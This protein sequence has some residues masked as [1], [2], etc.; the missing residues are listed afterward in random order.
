MPDSDFNGSNTETLDVLRQLRE[1]IMSGELAPGARLHQVPLSEALGISRTPLREAMA[2]LARDGLLEYAPNRGYS[3]RAFKWADIEQAYAVRARLEGMASA[4]C[5]RQGIPA[6]IAARLQACLETGDQILA[7]GVLRPDD[8]PPYRAMNVAFHEAILEAA[9]N[10][11]I[12]DF[13]R[14]TQNVPLASDRLFI[15]EDHATILRSHDD[16]HRI[17]HCIVG[18]DAE[19][20]E[21]LMREHIIFAGQ[22]LKLIEGREPG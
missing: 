4:I 3:V 1:R 9:G 17:V 6:G 8:L 18:G 5:A 13:V 10:I 16:H 12:S 2:R 19:R 15:W 14:Q 11:W 7:A 20:A 21:G 22:V